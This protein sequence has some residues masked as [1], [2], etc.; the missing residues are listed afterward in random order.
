MIFGQPASLSMSL[1][2]AT[3]PQAVTSRWS[4]TSEEFARAVFTF[5]IAL[6]AVALPLALHG[7]SP[8]LGMPAAIAI[9][10]VMAWT[11]PQQAIAIVLFSFVF[12]NLLVALMAGLWRSEDDFD[13][14]RGY[15]FLLLAAVWLGVVAHALVRWRDRPRGLDLYIK[16]SV[17]LFG[18]IG[19]YF[20]IGYAL[21]GFNAIVYLRNIV[22]PFLLFQI[23]LIVFATTPAGLGRVIMIIA[24]LVVL[25]GLAEFFFRDQWFAA[26]NSE[27]Y[28]ELTGLANYIGLDFDR[29]ASRTGIVYTSIIDTFRTEFF[30]SPILAELGGTVLRMAGPNM[31]AISFAY[32]LSFLL[33]FCLFRGRLVWV[34]PLFLLLFLT[35]A[36][37][38]LLVV[39]MVASGWLA[40][41]IVG[42]KPALFVFGL[43][44]LAYV[45]TGIVI[46]LRYGDYH[47]IG[48][49]GALHDFVANPV[50]RGIGSGGNLSPDF[51]R[52]DWDAAQAAGRTPFAV[53]SSI[54]VLIY[55]M[56]IFALFPIGFYVWI[57]WRVLKIADATGN[58]LQLAV[59]FAILAVLAN[60]FFQEEAL[61]APL[62][63]ALH[64]TVAGMILGA[65]IRTG[66]ES[67]GRR[68]RSS[69]AMVS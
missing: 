33:I 26:T 24:G 55:Q 19:L 64:M 28:W 44:L 67:P 18:A 59:G 42:L 45:A 29:V 6:V 8:L 53:E 52:I 58:G 22:T 4:S 54:G 20:L 12:Q 32:L 30:N 57:A 16:A 2:S 23:C 48:L 50:G 46:G 47:V 13:L 62:S 51:I 11:M 43:V 68:P 25:C 37:G 34:V 38:P 63:M 60:G 14:V 41:R 10:G 35:S 27:T 49:M 56:G 3:H 15:N 39:M 66:L 1:T 36:K 17:A 7:I 31:H 40:A 65:A 61:F 9:A 69:G 5:L 21:N